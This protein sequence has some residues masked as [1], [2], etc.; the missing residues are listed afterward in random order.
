M[1]L[2]RLHLV[3]YQEQSGTLL[4]PSGAGT[5]PPW[6]GR[7][8]TWGHRGHD[9]TFVRNGSKPN[10][11]RREVTP[12][13]AAVAA[14]ATGRATPAEEPRDRNGSAGS[15]AS[16]WHGTW[17][18]TAERVSEHV[19]LRWLLRDSLCQLE[20]KDNRAST[21]REGPGTSPRFSR[22]V[23]AV[24]NRPWWHPRPHTRLLSC[25]D[26]CAGPPGCAPAPLSAGPSS[27]AHLHPSVRARLRVPPGPRLAES[28]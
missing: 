8:G 23:R 10:E 17:S 15:H 12:S 11:R 9:A 5:G 25:A 14:R 4:P 16:G 6:E 3:S 24:R 22:V 27:Y 18:V 19:S 1:T 20:R 28:A 7:G 26:S 21:C 2:R 13:D